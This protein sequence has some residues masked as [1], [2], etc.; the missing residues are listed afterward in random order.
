MT[1][2]P[3]IDYRPVSA[4]EDC[5]ILLANGEVPEDRP[6][7]SDIISLRWQGYGLVPGCPPD[8]CQRTEDGD[9]PEPWFSWSACEICGS[10]L[11]GN[12]Q[13]VTPFETTEKETTILSSVTG[14]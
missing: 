6:D 5:M 12:S 13:H 1:L 7:L 10:G 11:A 8:C 4:C 9:S 14:I 3:R 2:A